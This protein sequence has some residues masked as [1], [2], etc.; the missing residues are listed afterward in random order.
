MVGRRVRSLTLFARGTTPSPF[1][2]A[3]AEA[4]APSERSP[5]IRQA[6]TAALTVRQPL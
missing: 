2:T 5:F 4:L 1:R 3:T 6:R